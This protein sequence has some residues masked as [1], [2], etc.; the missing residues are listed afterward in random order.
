MPPRQ[1]TL[2]GFRQEHNPSQICQYTVICMEW[3]QT[4]ELVDLEKAYDSVPR[5]ILWCVSNKN[6]VKY[7]SVQ[8]YLWS[9]CK[10]K[11][12]WLIKRWSTDYKMGSSNTRLIPFLF[13]RVMNETSKEIQDENAFVYVTSR[14]RVLA[15]KT[16][17]VNIIS[18]SLRQTLKVWV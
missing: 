3:L 15:D 16:K 10:H 18:E 5:D 13:A 8:R 12:L 11:N 17:V 1:W 4:K 2:M 7:A 6:T 14:R 9:N